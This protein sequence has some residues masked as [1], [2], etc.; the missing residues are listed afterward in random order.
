MYPAARLS[1][2]SIKRS[3]IRLNPD[4]ESLGDEVILRID[5]EFVKMSSAIV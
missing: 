2:L 3:D 1:M 4:T 5:A